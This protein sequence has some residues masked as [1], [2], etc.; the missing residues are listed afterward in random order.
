MRLHFFNSAVLADSKL[1]YLFTVAPLS[2]P[3]LT[4]VLLSTTVMSTEEAMS[5]QYT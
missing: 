3:I 2:L 5:T 4:R 1:D